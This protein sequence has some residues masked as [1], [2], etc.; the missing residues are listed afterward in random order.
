MVAGRAPVWITHAVVMRAAMLLAKG[1]AAPPQANQ[2]PHR[3]LRFGQCL[4][5]VLAPPEPEA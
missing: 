4:E 1:S 3:A 5:L 2:W